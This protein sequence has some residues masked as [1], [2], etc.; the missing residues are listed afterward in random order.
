M[1]NFWNKIVARLGDNNVTTVPGMVCAALA[2]LLTL[3]KGWGLFQWGSLIGAALIISPHQTPSRGLVIGWYLIT[4]MCNEGISWIF[5]TVALVLL[6]RSIQPTATTPDPTPAPRPADGEE[7]PGSIRVLHYI[8]EYSDRYD[9]IIDYM[10][11]AMVPVLRIPIPWI[12]Y[13]L[14]D[15]NV[16]IRDS[17]FTGTDPEKLSLIQNQEYSSSWMLDLLG[18]GTYRF[19]T[20]KI[21]ETEYKEWRYI[22]AWFII[23]VSGRWEKK[24]KK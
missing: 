6:L 20:K 16:V 17:V 7:H 11:H 15:Q 14:T 19:Q 12:T 22:P 8:G 10:A 21:G 23:K 18:C 3:T 9:A 24:E 1:R 13:I 2:A 4:L 5:G